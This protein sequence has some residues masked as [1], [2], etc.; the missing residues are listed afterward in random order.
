MLCDPRDFKRDIGLIGE[1]SQ[2]EVAHLDELYDEVARVGRQRGRNLTQ[3]Q[4]PTPSHTIAIAEIGAKSGAHHTVKIAVADDDDGWKQLRIR[5]G[6]VIAA[7][8]DTFFAKVRE[9]RR[10][11]P[12]L[13]SHEL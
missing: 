10:V 7:L 11:G 8:V 2:D 12:S 6:N 13:L 3:L 1:A 5:L 4:V 9:A